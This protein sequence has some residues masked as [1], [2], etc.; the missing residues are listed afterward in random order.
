MVTQTD[1]PGPADELT[2]VPGYTR[3]VV[4]WTK[5][6]GRRDTA[7]HHAHHSIDAARRHVRGLLQ[8][9]APGAV[10]DDVLTLIGFDG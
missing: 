3:W 5:N 7:F 2:G 6:D 8:M 4:E 9:R 1:E 10:R